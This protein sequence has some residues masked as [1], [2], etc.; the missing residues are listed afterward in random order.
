MSSIQKSFAAIG[1]FLVASAVSAKDLNSKFQLL[2]LPQKVEVFADNGLR[3]C[4][5][6]FIVTEG[7]LAMPVLGPLAGCLPQFRNA[8]KGI[9]LRLTDK[10]TPESEE[11]YLL[12]VGKMES[13]FV[14]SKCRPFLW[15]PDI[16]AIDGRQP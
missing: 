7:E 12:E 8:G 9:V 5:L 15:M 16:G 2:P 10:G 14:Q 4:D 6:S 3:G 13:P 11:G 1:L